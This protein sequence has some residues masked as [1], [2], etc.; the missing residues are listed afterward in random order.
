MF[1]HILLI[2]NYSYNIIITY[3]FKENFK[4]KTMEENIQGLTSKEVAERVKQK[5]T[6]KVK[7]RTDESFLRIIFKREL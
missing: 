5:K 6:N 7:T 3:N 1:G 2:L 4:G